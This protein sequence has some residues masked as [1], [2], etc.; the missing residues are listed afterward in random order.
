MPTIKSPLQLMPFE[1]MRF[2]PR[3]EYGEMAELVEICGSENGS[4]MMKC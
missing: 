4:E 3:F 2:T 1:Q